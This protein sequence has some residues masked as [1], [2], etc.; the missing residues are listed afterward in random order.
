GERAGREVVTDEAEVEP[1]PARERRRPQE[2]GAHPGRRGTRALEAHDGEP[3]GGGID[4][5]WRRRGGRGG[6]ARSTGTRRR[7]RCAEE[8][9][10]EVTGADF[11][12][13]SRVRYD[14]RAESVRD[15][16]RGSERP[17]THGLLPTPAP[18][19]PIVAYFV[20]FAQ[21]TGLAAPPRSTR[22]R[23]RSSATR[24]PASVSSRGA[25]PGPMWVS[26]NV[27]WALIRSR[28]ARMS[29]GVRCGPQLS[30]QQEHST[31]KTSAPS[32]SGTSASHMTVS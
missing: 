11:R 6:D 17:P 1:L 22:K 7:R 10:R 25:C 21:A 12:G 14:E 3:G 30:P 20:G 28:R 26:T 24:M 32:A 19:P 8:V 27:V 2:P 31:T 15:D 16:E 23:P 9:R 18:L 5:G 4:D 13:R 29:R